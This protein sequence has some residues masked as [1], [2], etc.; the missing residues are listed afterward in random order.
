[1]PKMV[2]G[3]SNMQSRQFK[4]ASLP[5]MNVSDS[6]ELYFGCFTRAFV[7]F[8]KKKCS[9]FVLLRLIFWDEGSKRKSAPVTGR[10]SPGILVLPG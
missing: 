4:C 10:K 5:S 3:S 7:P 6:F 9:F 1:M 8:E 2:R